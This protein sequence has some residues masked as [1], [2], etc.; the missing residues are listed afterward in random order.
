MDFGEPRR[1]EGRV[2]AGGQD[3]GRGVQFT[4]NGLEDFAD[5]PAVAVDRTR[6]HGLGGRF[7]D[8]GFRFGEINLGEE[9]SALVQVVG[10]GGQPRGDHATEIAGLHPGPSHHVEGDCRSEV[11]HDGGR[12]NPGVHGHG[13]G[14]AIGADLFGTGIVDADG[15][16]ALVRDLVERSRGQSLPEKSGFLRDDGGDDGGIEFEGLQF[17]DERCSQFPGGD[18]LDV[19]SVLTGGCDRELGAS[20]GVIDQEEPHGLAG[21]KAGDDLSEH[22]KGCE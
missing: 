20:V 19:V 2:A 3:G 9:G 22:E 8:G 12:S 13:I 14:Q 5:H 16:G 1:N 7:A 10:H 11:D 4:L 6:P 18:V 21:R 15:Q 17:F